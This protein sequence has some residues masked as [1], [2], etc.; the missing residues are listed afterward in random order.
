MDNATLSP[1]GTPGYD[2][3][4]KI[5][6]LLEYL[7]QRFKSVYNPGQEVAIDEAMIKFQG[8]S[9]I[10]QYIPLKPIKRGIKRG[11]KVWV[12]G[13]S[14]NGYFSRLEVYTGRKDNTTEQGLGASV[15][16]ELTHD[17]QGRWHFVYFDNSKALLCDLEA[18]GLYGCGTCEV[19]RKL[20]P[21]ALK[22]PQL[23]KRYLYIIFSLLCRT[24][25]CALYKKEV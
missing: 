1:P 17:F 18:V 10:K 15:V 4:G 24:L 12:L 25:E 13:D 14:S 3:L 9:S 8:R 7:Q 16:K 21:A 6:P 11:I 23:K 5:Q 19:D 2:H 22:K 20:F